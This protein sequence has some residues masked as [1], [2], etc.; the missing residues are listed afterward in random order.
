[1]G[2]IT[3][4]ESG[5][6]LMYTRGKI[7]LP[8]TDLDMILI[9]ATSVMSFAAHAC[10]AKSLGSENAAM[11]S[12]VRKSCEVL[13]AFVLQVVIFGVLLFISDGD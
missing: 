13:F 8:D 11:V 2:L 4:I 6:I 7:E 5:V 1:M 12:M 9:F 10:L 3:A